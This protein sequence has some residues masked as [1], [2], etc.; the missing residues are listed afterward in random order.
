METR[1]R[2]D[3]RRGY[4]SLFL[5]ACFSVVIAGHEAIGANGEASKAAP[6]IRQPS[7]PY[8]GV[9]CLYTVLRLSGRDVDL[10]KLVR[11]EYIGSHRGSSL[12]EL[13]KAAEDNAL[14][15]VPVRTMTSRALRSCRDPI[16][17]HVKFDVMSKTYNHYELFLGTENGRARMLNPPEPVRSVPFKELV[18]RWDGNGLIVSAEPIDTGAIFAPARRQFMICAAIAVATV[19]A[20][21]CARGRLPHAMSDSHRGLL[22]V[23]AIQSAMFGITALLCAVLYHFANDEGLLANAAA[24]TSVQQAHIGNFVPRIGAE[25]VHKLLGTDTVFIDARYA[26]DYGG[27]HLEGAR[28]IPVDTND[29]ER[30]TMTASIPEHSRIVVYCQSASCK[31]AENMALWLKQ[32][33][34]SD[35]AIY[36]GGWADWVARNGKTGGR[37]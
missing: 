28:S 2:A 27:G 15:A 10:R 22:S 3:T 24:T 19:L 7:G 12:T 21:R 14:Y 34:F 23:S 16:I 30:H 1:D 4:L 8:C 11:P 17:L 18:P 32:K 13:R 33:G 6:S 9:Y 35:V 37:I 36:R 31:F 20:V 5:S 29:M 26:H 25:K